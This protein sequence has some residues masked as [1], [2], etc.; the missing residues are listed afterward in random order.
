M[1]GMGGEDLSWYILEEDPPLYEEGPP[2]RRF[3]SALG[4]HLATWPHAEIDDSIDV[5]ANCATLASNSR[6]PLGV[7]FQHGL[8]RWPKGAKKVPWEML[9]EG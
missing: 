9:L 2:Q 4:M 3:G 1:E 7:C 8:Q 6:G 5:L